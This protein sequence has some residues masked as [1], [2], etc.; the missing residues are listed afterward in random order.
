MYFILKMHFFVH[1]IFY[2]TFDFDQWI[3][4]DPFILTRPTI[5]SHSMEVPERNSCLHSEQLICA[6]GFR[7]Q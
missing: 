4:R 2:S 6:Y 1:T 5:L 7:K 3:F